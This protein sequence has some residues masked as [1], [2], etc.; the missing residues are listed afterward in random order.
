[1][2]GLRRSRQREVILKELKSVT[3]H[4]TAS[5]LHEMVRKELPSISLGTVYRNL[6][7]LSEKGMIQKLEISSDQAR[8][9]GNPTWHLHVHC[10]HCDKITDV[11][12]PPPGATPVLP[13]EME[14]HEI[15]GLSIEYIGICLDCC[16][17]LSPQERLS[18]QRR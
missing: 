1:M 15:L 7:L 4:P 17:R 2:A 18:L 3:S 13:M 6:E 9:D 11:H 8:F 12:N 16:T 10:S 5:E 14:G